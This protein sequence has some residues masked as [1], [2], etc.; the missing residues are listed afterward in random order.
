MLLKVL[1]RGQRAVDIGCGNG[2]STA[3]LARYSREVLGVDA[4]GPDE[5]AAA[6]LPLVLSYGLVVYG[7][8][9]GPTAAGVANG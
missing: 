7:P 3:I 6:V 1:P 4:V 5:I 9:G 2:Y 8:M